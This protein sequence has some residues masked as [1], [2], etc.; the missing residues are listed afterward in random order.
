MPH[1][2]YTE[3]REEL[4]ARMEKGAGRD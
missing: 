3:H 4:K 2:V 1:G